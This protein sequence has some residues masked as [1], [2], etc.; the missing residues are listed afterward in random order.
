[1]TDNRNIKNILILDDDPDYRKLL[2]I[3]LHK[4]FKD[5]ALTEYDPLSR[6]IPAENFDWSQYDVLILDYDLQI[7][8]ATGLEILDA[9][10]DNRD[11]PATIMLT[12]AGNEE[13]SVRAMKAGIYDYLRKEKLDL[14]QLQKTIAEAHDARV[15]ERVRTSSLDAARKVARLEANKIFAIYKSKYQKIQLKEEDRLNERKQKLRQEIKQNKKI[16]KEIEIEKAKAEQARQLAAEELEKLK[17]RKKDKKIKHDKEAQQSLKEQLKE[18]Q[19]RVKEMKK[20]V[21]KTR[22]DYEQVEDKLNKTSWQLEKGELMSDHLEDDL[23]EFR[24]EF[25]EEEIRSA[26]PKQKVKEEPGEHDSLLSEISSQ[27]GD[28]ND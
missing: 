5:T 4:A 2:L 15:D 19:A 8:D 26:A 21:D 14:K 17:A 16:L 11:F 9:N 7:K 1:M 27:L 18:A 20:G 25:E 13:V 10:R 6:G 12:G 24:A 23:A 22:K 28:D 3:F